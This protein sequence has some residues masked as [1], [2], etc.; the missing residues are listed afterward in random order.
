VSSV[1]T[2]P[3]DARG[4]GSDGHPYLRYWNMK[5][6]REAMLPIPPALSE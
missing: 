5:A 6:K 2:L 4:I 1:V 3:R